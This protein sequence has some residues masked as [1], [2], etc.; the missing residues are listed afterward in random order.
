MTATSTPVSK[1]SIL[2]SFVSL[3]QNPVMATSSGW[4]NTMPMHTAQNEIHRLLGP[5]TQATP[6]FPNNVGEIT[7][8]NV[9]YLLHGFAV[10]LTRHRRA[11]GWLRTDSVPTDLGYALTSY[12][13]NNVVWFSYPTIPDVGT[14]ITGTILNNFMN[15]LRLQ[16]Q[17]IKTDNNHASD[18]VV[19][20]NS[21]HGSCHGSRGRR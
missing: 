8:T 17:N 3:V 16:V 11:R 6:S 7:T 19:C 20:H 1:A 13:V 14:P 15:A 12:A 2:S 21:C 5:R 4:N 10:A 9:F 18:I